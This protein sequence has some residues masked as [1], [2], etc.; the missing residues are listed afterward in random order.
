VSA[1]R[2]AGMVHVAVSIGRDKAVACQLLALAQYA[3]AAARNH[4][5]SPA[6][7]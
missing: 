3:P 5:D 4:G 2:P 6:R 7:F 1:A